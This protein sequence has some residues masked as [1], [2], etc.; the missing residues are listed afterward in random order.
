MWLCFV[1]FWRSF[2]YV[3]NI[4]IFFQRV[5]CQTLRKKLNFN[6]TQDWG[7]HSYGIHGVNQINHFRLST[8][9][10]TNKCLQQMSSTNHTNKFQHKLPN[11]SKPT[12]HIVSLHNTDWSGMSLFILWLLFL[13]FFF[14]SCF[15]FVFFL[16]RWWILGLH[17]WHIKDVY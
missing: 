12:R 5:F 10:A 2:F 8:T 4:K 17:K 6:K 3:D 1:H 16:L 9:N 7:N 14:P 15:C 11:T 13:S